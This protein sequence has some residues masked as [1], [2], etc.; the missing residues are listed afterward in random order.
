VR[1]LPRRASLGR[2]LFVAVAGMLLPLVAVGV[3]GILAFRT[4]GNALEDFRAETVGQS[5]RIAK[6]RDLMVAV[7]DAG[8]LYAESLDPALGERFLQASAQIDEGFDGLE[9]LNS[10]E[11]RLL[12]TAARAR[13]ETART[14][15]EAVI[16]DGTGDDNSLDPFHDHVDGAAALLSDAVAEN[17]NEVS[18]EIGSLRARERLQFLA[19]L[20]TLIVGSIVGGLLARRAYRSVTKPLALLEEAAG[21]FGSD[22]FTYLI[23]VSGDDELAHVSSAFNSMAEKLKV[24]REALHQQAL[25]DQLTG[26]PNRTLFVERV[27]RAIARA[28]RRKTPVSAMYLDVDNFKEINDTFGHQAGDEVLIAVAER[29]KG[30]LRTEDTASRLG[31]DEFGVL[32]EED[33]DGATRAAERLIGAL[34]GT[35]AVTAGELQVGVSIGVA[36]RQGAEELDELLRQA[37]AAMYLAKASGK[38][39]WRVFG[40]DIDAALLGIRSPVTELQRAIDDRGF[41]VH[42]Q[43]VLDLQSGRIDGVEALV[44]WDHPER[45]LLAPSEFLQEAEDTGHILE[46]DRWILREACHQVRAWQKNLPGAEDL[47]VHVNVSARTLQ[48]PGLAD[49]IAEVLRSSGLAPG[50]L[51]LE[52]TETTLVLDPQAAAG[53][54]TQLKALGVRVALDDFGTG[55][56]SLSHLLRFPIDTIKI[57]RSFVSAVGRDEQRSQLVQA[58]IDLG[59]TLGLRVVAEGIETPDQLDFLRTIGCEQGQGY[60]FAKP[61]GAPELERFLREKGR[62]GAIEPSIAKVLNMDGVRIA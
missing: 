40:P 43:P 35:Y 11:E 21:R 57:D 54:L 4:T 41:V 39:G 14:S 2:H 30:A 17:V 13:W 6:V 52:I 27:E 50:H 12:V 58:M 1:I 22:D 23:D 45:G 46:I 34:V 33:V 29:L 44:R 28:E 61:L 47:S 20:L 18:D 19:S 60:L 9:S 3:L 55:F 38:G 36:A 24:S 32:L 62:A 16:R 25:H 31:G 53:E 7:D 10:I 49:E 56:S 48:H 5:T 51:I 37:D 59:G 8:E 15:I 42:Y 26:L